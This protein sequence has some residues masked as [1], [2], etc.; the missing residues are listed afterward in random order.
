MSKSF[1]KVSDK[2]SPELQQRVSKSFDISDQILDILEKK[3]ITQKQLADKL[4]KAESEVSKWMKGDHNFTIDTIVKVEIALE[5]KI[6]DTPNNYQKESEKLRNYI[7]A[8][9]KTG[10]LNNI[11]EIPVKAVIL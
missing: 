9:F 11:I 2:L 6:I 4:G 7:P 8:S 10:H 5:E 1:K 3:G